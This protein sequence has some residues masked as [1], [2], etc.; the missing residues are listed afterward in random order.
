MFHHRTQ[1]GL[2]QPAPTA[3]PLQ[4]TVI[5]KENITLPFSISGS[6]SPQATLR[7]TVQ[8]IGV[9]CAKKL[10]GL[11]R[12]SEPLKVNICPQVQGGKTPSL[13][14]KMVNLPANMTFTATPTSPPP[15]PI[16]KYVKAGPEILRYLDSQL[17]AQEDRHD[18][19]LKAH[20][21][22]HE[23]QLKAQEER[24]ASQMQDLAHQIQQLN[25]QLHPLTMRALLDE[26]VNGI[27]RAL[28]VS[29]RGKRRPSGKE[30]WDRDTVFQAWQSYLR[31][32]KA[33]DPSSA[34]YLSDES[35]VKMV[36]GV[37]G[38]GLHEF[39]V[40]GNAAAHDYNEEQLRKYCS[41]TVFDPPLRSA[42]Q[43]SF[44]FLFPGEKPLE[45]KTV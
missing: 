30:T 5:Y 6:G 19:Q 39:R 22:R 29:S 2:W 28:G 37:D 41:S 15:G 27:G 42:I 14:T 21:E 11:L 45:F 17:K 33:V 40:A 36:F 23:S 12:V 24:H 1:I 32:P 35:T 10:Q 16:E 38:V 44:L 43:K 34:A 7:E 31:T 26:V 4:A 25:G 20:D 18:S 3:T 13:S 8:A 9:D